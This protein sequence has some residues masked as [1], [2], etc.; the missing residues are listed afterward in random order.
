M[1]GPFKLVSRESGAGPGFPENFD[2]S[3]TGCAE[4]KETQFH[5]SCEVV[6]QH[7]YMILHMLF[8]NNVLLHK[9]LHETLHPSVRHG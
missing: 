9:A 8:E 1:L 3:T 6:E 7:S 4:I 5:R 2:T